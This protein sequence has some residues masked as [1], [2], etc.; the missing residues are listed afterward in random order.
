[1]R[2]VL[3]TATTFPRWEG[4]A[5][6]VFVLELA[7][8]LVRRGI[9][10]HLLAPHAAGART[11]EIVDGIRVR[12]FR[13]APPSFERLAYGSGILPNVKRNP[14]L[15]FLL[16]SFLAGQLAAALR[17]LRTADIRCVNAHWIFPQ[18]FVGLALKSCGE[19]R[20]V[21][22]VHGGDIFALSRVPALVP[23]LRRVLSRSDAVTVNS[24]ATAAAVRAVSPAVNPVL[25]PMGV[26]A[27]LFS[28]GRADPALRERHAPRGE[29]L[30]LFCGRLAL[31]KGVRYLLEAMPAILA[32]KPRTVLVVAGEG[33]EGA[34][35]RGLAQNLGLGESVRFLGAVPN[36]ALPAYY[37][38]S[39]LFVC[40]S[41]V[42]ERGDTEGL[43]VVLLEAAASGL[44]AV[45]SRVG[46][47]PDVVRDGETGVLVAERSPHEIARA[48]LELLS[49]AGRRER[50]GRQ[51]RTLV[52]E[53]FTWD[54]IAERF[55]Q[56]LFEDSLGDGRERRVRGRS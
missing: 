35:L 42:D 28:P 41:I 24:L 25:I 48:V 17:I 55:V 49:D 56:T 31:K 27:T 33:E 46:G 16:P 10:V 4:D 39:D 21:T 15:L 2:R 22:T 11:A 38:S 52:L 37:A 14:L 5:R 54:R 29:M 32:Q 45:A 43:G 34:S 40:P 19:V 26:D 12:R 30:L 1:V 36:A 9:E 18:G 8:A 6:P 23:V 50:L 44:P 47:I 20:L 53:R 51:A 13:Y 3:L 7:R